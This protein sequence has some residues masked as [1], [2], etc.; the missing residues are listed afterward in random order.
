MQDYDVIV[1][2]GSIAGL[3][4]ASEAAKGGARVVVFEEHPEVGEPEKC[5][6]LVSLRG[7]RK[8]GYLPRREAIQSEISSAVIHSPS[9]RR[10]ELNAASLEVVVLD[11][12]DYDKQVAETALANGAEI[13]TGVR[14]SGTSKKENGI[15]VRAGETTLHA[16]YFVDATGPS[17]SPRRGILPAAKYEVE[18]E[19]VREHTVEVFLD[20]AKYPG[21][22]AWVIPFGDRVAK[23]GAA[24]LGTSPFRALDG[25]LSGRPVRILR[26]VSAPIYVGGP[27]ASF[28]EGNTLLVGESAGQ[29]KP[30]TAGGIMTSIGGAVIAA[31][32][33]CACLGGGGRASLE[34]YQG[35]W[36]SSFLREI[37][38]MLRLR[39][40]FE[41]LS[42]ED[43]DRV[44][45]ALAAP[46]LARKLA[47]SDF[48]FHAS[49]VIGAVGIPGL[50]KVAKV[51]ASAEARSLLAEM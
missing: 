16:G 32:C 30:T 35:E 31:R 29:V 27:A 44:I 14:V 21:F 6:G 24:G 36:E 26:R 17:S 28:V 51:V 5:D 40:I 34:R 39:R 45:A 33:V 46:K 8:Y 2:G 47:N 37:K 38:S 48:D 49:A 4:F 19:W 1:A 50:L 42:N 3:A 41:K 7:L 43:L 12:S 18:G 9:G 11:R 22:F 25:F 20:A 23:V 15:E 10:L 13:R